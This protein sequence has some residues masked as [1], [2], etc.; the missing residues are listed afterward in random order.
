MRRAD[1][2]PRHRHASRRQPADEETARSLRHRPRR[3]DSL[4]AP[5]DS[6][7]V[8]D[9]SSNIVRTAHQVTDLSIGNSPKRRTS[10][11]DRP[12]AS[13]SFALDYHFGRFEVHRLPPVVDVAIHATRRSPRSS[14]GSL[15]LP[16][17]LRS[18]GISSRTDGALPPRSCRGH[19]L[20]IQSVAYIVQRIDTLATSLLL[21]LLLYVHGGSSPS[22]GTLGVWGGSWSTWTTGPGI[23]GDRG[24]LPLRHPAAESAF[25]P[26]RAGLIPQG[27]AFGVSSALILVADRPGLHR[28]GSRREDPAVY[29]LRE[30]TMVER[31]LI[32]PRVIIFYL[33]LWILPFRSGSTSTTPLRLPLAAG[34]DHHDSLPLGCG[35]AR[36]SRGLLAA[37]PLHLVLILWLLLHL[38]IESSVIGL[39]LCF[40]HRMYLPLWLALMT[41]ISCLAASDEGDPR[42]SSSPCS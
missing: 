18:P 3:R 22:T 36:R 2:L 26:G 21:V 1:S 11:L 6:P 7:F 37:R 38:V 10:P 35:R 23:D 33:S 28:R 30:F 20:Q 41:A 40:E 8:F 16:P 29:R 12:V 13:L 27:V 5:L 39:E 17:A 4:S 24:G 42:R 9:D 25:F 34:A 32:Q 19:P 15:R 31:L 14:P